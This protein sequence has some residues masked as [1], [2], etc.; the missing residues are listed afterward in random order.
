MPEVKSSG[1][2]V[3][4]CKCK[5]LRFPVQIRKE[6]EAYRR[7]RPT[8]ILKI[9][10]IVCRRLRSIIAAKAVGQ[11]HRR[12][13]S[14]I[15]DHE[16]FASVRRSHHYVNPLEYFSNR[17]HSHPPSPA[18]LEVL[19]RRDEARRTERIWPVKRLL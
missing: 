14:Q 6:C 2:L 7:S 4:A 8:R 3:G 13:A 16:L 18:C 11:Y 9:A 17:L 1:I 12:I 5:Q 19:D 10:R 15:R